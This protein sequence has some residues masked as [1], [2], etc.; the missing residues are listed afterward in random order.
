[1]R[2]ERSFILLILIRFGYQVHIFRNSAMKLCTEI[3]LKD[4]FNLINKSKDKHIWIFSLFLLFSF[5]SSIYKIE[6]F[7]FDSPI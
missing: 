5:D 7:S 2:C 3:G 1:M 4:A 6:L